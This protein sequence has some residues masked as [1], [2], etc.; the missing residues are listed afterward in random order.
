MSNFVC[1][2]GLGLP[3]S[4]VAQHGVKRGDHLAYDGDKVRSPNRLK[5]G[6]EGEEAEGEVR[7]LWPSA[8]RSC[9]TAVESKVRLRGR[10]S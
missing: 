6:G 8:P 7:A 4:A 3:A 9:F 10:C 5:K 2:S 1:S